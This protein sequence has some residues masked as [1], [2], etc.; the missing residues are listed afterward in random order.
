MTA[1]ATASATASTSQSNTQCLLVSKPLASSVLLHGQ[2]S[3][4]VSTGL[5]ACMIKN[6]EDYDASL[7]TESY[8]K[9]G[10]PCPP[11]KDGTVQWL[12]HVVPANKGIVFLQTTPHVLPCLP[13]DK[14]ASP[15]KLVLTVTAY[16]PLCT[17]CLTRKFVLP[18]NC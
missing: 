13:F 17:M 10:L 1:T 11:N 18:K 16:S 5:Q 15:H 8:R 12:K 3:N 7:C 14:V 2:A 4:T 6:I 9:Y